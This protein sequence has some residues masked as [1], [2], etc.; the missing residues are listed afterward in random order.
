MDNVSME[1][2]FVFSYFRGVKPKLCSHDVIA[3]ILF[4]L[5]C[6]Q[7]EIL[8]LIYSL[9]YCKFSINCLKRKKTTW[10]LLRALFC[11]YFHTIWQTWTSVPL[12]I[13]IKCKIL[14]SSRN[15]S[16][17]V[18]ASCRPQHKI[19]TICFVYACVCVDS[20]RQCLQL[21]QNIMQYQQHW[22]KHWK[23]QWKFFDEHM[24]F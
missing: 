16:V 9:A 17:Y 24:D 5:M 10:R 7:N 6:T 4:F 18:G 3:R 20:W 11:D 12:L 14:E 8:K 15:L 23:N 13:R 22:F 21:C 2:I 1:K 19:T